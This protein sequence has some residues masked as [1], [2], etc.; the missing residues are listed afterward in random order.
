MA[1][2]IYTT[3]LNPLTFSPNSQREPLANQDGQGNAFPATEWTVISQARS[4]GETVVKHGRD[5][6]C[7]RYWKPLYLYLRRKG[8]SHEDASDHVQGFLQFVLNGKFLSYVDR[9]GGRF[10]S[11]LVKSLENWRVRERRQALAQKRGGLVEHVPFEEISQFEESADL[12]S[13]EPPELAY[14]RQWASDMVG[15]AF[16]SLRGHYARRG[17]GELF[18][19]LRQALPGGTAMRS[20]STLASELEMTEGALKKA[21]HDLR[22]AFAAEMRQEIRTTVLDPEDAEEELRYLIAVMTRR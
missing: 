17:K 12:G 5:S 15:R 9:D 3:Q 7:V 4:D 11:Y 1:F 20:Y 16:V 13:Q 19:A 18:E 10:R 21:V 8:E 6:L 14:D 2:V 22:R